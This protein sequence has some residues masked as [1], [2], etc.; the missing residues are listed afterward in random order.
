MS[1]ISPSASTPARDTSA[2]RQCGQPSHRGAIAHALGAS[3]LQH[4]CDHWQGEDP[5]SDTLVRDCD[6]APG[7]EFF[8]VPEAE[9]EAQVHPDRALDDVAWKAV[10]RERKQGNGAQLYTR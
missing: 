8:N 2:C 4:A 6:A 10:A 5:T 9:C 7:E 3:G 1:R